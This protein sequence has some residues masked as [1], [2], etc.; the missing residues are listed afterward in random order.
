M[1][2]N[3]KFYIMKNLTFNEELTT[4]L[5]FMM[6]HFKG[7]AEREYNKEIEMMLK[8][9]LT[10]QD[11]DDSRERLALATALLDFF[12]EAKTCFIAELPF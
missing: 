10:H 1:F 6:I 9:L 4:K 3:L 11:L 5:Y 2:N 8:G 7:I 12:R